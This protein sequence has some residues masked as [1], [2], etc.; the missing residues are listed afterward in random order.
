MKGIH[1]LNPQ[2]LSSHNNSSQRQ[3]KKKKK[4][5]PESPPPLKQSKRILSL[6]YREI[7][8]KFPF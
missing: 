6:G 2:N 1:Q 5:K 8:I 3:K 7:V 4:K